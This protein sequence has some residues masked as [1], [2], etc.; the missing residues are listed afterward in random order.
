MK[1]WPTAELQFH[2][3][4]EVSNFS[5]E[6]QRLKIQVLRFKDSHIFALVSKPGSNWC[7]VTC[8]GNRLNTHLLV[9]VDGRPIYPVSINHGLS[10]WGLPMCTP[11]RSKERSIFLACEE[12]EPSRGCE[13]LRMMRMTRQ[14]QKNTTSSFSEK[15]L[16]R[17][18]KDGV[19]I[20]GHTCNVFFEP[21]HIPRAQSNTTPAPCCTEVPKQHCCILQSQSSS[22]RS[23]QGYRTSV[24]THWDFYL[25]AVQKNHQGRFK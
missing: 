19:R 9:D 11:S 22:Q 18:Y 14:R 3:Q 24:P 10:V 7:K 25:D 13:H 5:S 8:Q 2:L 16:K 17:H 12:T 6:I 4:L 23:P 21:E 1:K 15:N 20:W